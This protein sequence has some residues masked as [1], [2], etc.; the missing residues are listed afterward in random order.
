[1]ATPHPFNLIGKG[2]P[3]VIISEH[4]VEPKFKSQAGFVRNIVVLCTSLY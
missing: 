2:F 4:S 1:M 3:E